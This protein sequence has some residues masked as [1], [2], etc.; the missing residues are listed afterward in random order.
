MTVSPLFADRIRNISITGPLIRIEFG[1]A[2]LPATEGGKPELVA[3]PTLVLPLEGLVA[4]MGMLDA[5]MKKLLAD[6]VLKHQTSASDTV[7]PASAVSP[8]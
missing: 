7:S 1:V 8:H 4:S 5:L 3:G 6:G 2:S